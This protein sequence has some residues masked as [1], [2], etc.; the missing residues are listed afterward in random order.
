MAYANGAVPAAALTTI[1]GCQLLDGTAHAFT[2]WQ[3]ACAAEGITLTTWGRYSGFRSL[4]VQAGMQKAYDDYHAGRAG[5]VAAM[6]KYGMDR[7][8]RARPANPGGSRHGDA[9]AVDIRVTKGSQ[10]RA[11]EIGKRFG[12]SWPFGLDDVNHMLHDGKTATTAPVKATAAKPAVRKTVIVKNGD[13]LSKVAART[14]ITLGKIKALNPQVRGPKY[15]IHP[16][17][18]IRVA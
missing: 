6:A 10:A 12:F 2:Q 5:G 9:R 18:T 13:T 8:S 17:D 16:G 11:R 4:V 15:V 7:T 3:A 14:K 1:A